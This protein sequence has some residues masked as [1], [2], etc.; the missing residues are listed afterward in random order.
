MTYF[1][2]L[3]SLLYF[4][5]DFYIYYKTGGYEAQISRF[6]ICRED[7]Y[8]KGINSLATTFFNYFIADVKRDSTCPIKRVVRRLVHILQHYHF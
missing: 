5:M 3:I 7:Y 6:M 2:L 4:Q 1:L 8:Y